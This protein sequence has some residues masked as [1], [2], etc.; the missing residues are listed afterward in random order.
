MKNI[1]FL[2]ILMGL[3]PFVYSCTNLDEQLFNQVGVS[4]FGSTLEEQDAL[5]G[6]IFPGLLR[7]ADLG[8]VRA[9][10]EI[11]GGAALIPRRGGDWWDGG[12]HAEL[13]LHSWD[14]SSGMTSNY[15]LGDGYGFWFDVYHNITLCNQLIA[16]LNSS[17]NDPNIIKNTLAE[18]R[19]VRAFWYY[20]LVDLFGNVPI[21]TNFYDLSLPTTIVPGQRKK[22]YNFIMAELD[23][24]TNLL[25]PGGP[26]PTYYGKFT[27]GAAFAIKAKMYLNAMVWNPEG[28][29]K[30]KE[31][32]DACDTLL[33]MGYQLDPV[34]RTNFIPN[35]EVS[36]EAIMSAVYKE[37]DGKNETL[38]LTLHYMSADALNIYVDPWNGICGMPD[39][40]QAFDTVNDTR[41]NQTYLVGPQISLKTGEQIFTAENRP[42]IYSIA[43][44]RHDIEDGW[45]STYQEPGARCW[46]WLPIDG[47]RTTEGND[48][49]FFRISD[50]YLMKAEALVRGGGSNGDATDL[51][52]AIRSRA[53]PDMPSK[54]YSS[55][56]LDDIMMER[57][58]ELAWEG[59]A[60]QDKIRFGHFSDA[61][62]GWKDADADNHYE[63]F[64]IPQNARNANPNLAQNPGYSK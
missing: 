15:I 25:P 55:V 14:A 40:V 13:T 35:N 22:V 29:S 2:I 6:S 32:A 4:D 11:S 24:I 1:K 47:L 43:I 44:P 45:G 52:N 63:L 56:T 30:W 18:I 3:M 8:G 20:K 31:C 50:V 27:K 62:P 46:K 51:V 39:Y 42:L 61:I 23:T 10:E 53:F 58:F 49:H 19:G 41:F 12:Q 57:R 21:I 60:R 16:M 37:G 33:N 5:V 9:I 34:W 38:A 54:L 28:G 59:F 48:F 7:S 64:P 36:K 26:N 17:N